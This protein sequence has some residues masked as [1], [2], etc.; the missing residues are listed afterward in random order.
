MVKKHAGRWP[1]PLALRGW[2]RQYAEDRP[3]LAGHEALLV[4]LDQQGARVLVYEP[5]RVIELQMQVDELCFRFMPDSQ[6]TPSKM[7]NVLLNLARTQA[8]AGPG[9]VE[10]LISRLKEPE[11]KKMVTKKAVK[12]NGQHRP[13]EKA[14]GGR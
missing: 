4:E 12:A 1:V 2:P 5:G 6:L 8:R 7:A 9:V 13:T 3:F 11:T 14:G 10:R